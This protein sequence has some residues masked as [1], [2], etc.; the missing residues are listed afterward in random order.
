VVLALLALKPNPF[1]F[2]IPL[3]GVCL[4]V[5]RH[6]KVILGGMACLSCL[7][8]LGRLVLPGW[9][10]GWMQ[11]SGK[12]YVAAR[13]PTIWGL[14]GDL[15]MQFW[16][17]IG[18]ILTI[19]ITFGVARVVIRCKDLSPQ[20]VVGLAVPAS[21][22]VTPYAWAYEHVLLFIPLLFLFPYFDQSL[23]KR[24]LWF[25]WVAVLP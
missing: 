16:Q 24:L 13:T 21:L 7:L 11:A 22:L 6:W 17:L 25:G 18:V 1:L 19:A 9:L 23:G 3:V 10:M 12:A 20:Q 4:L 14:A 8:I 5:Q 15:S 2:F